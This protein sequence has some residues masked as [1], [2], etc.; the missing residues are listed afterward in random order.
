MAFVLISVSSFIA[1]KNSTNVVLRIFFSVVFWNRRIKM[2]KE[3]RRNNCFCQSLS[4]A[5]SQCLPASSAIRFGINGLANNSL[6]IVAMYRNHLSRL[7]NIRGRSTP[8]V[9]SLMASLY[10]SPLR[11]HERGISPLELKGVE[12]VPLTPEEDFLCCASHPSTCFHRTMACCCCC[13]RSHFFPCSK[14]HWGHLECPTRSL[15][16]PTQTH[17]RLEALI[18]LPRPTWNM[19]L[20]AF[21]WTAFP[22]DLLL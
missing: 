12:V 21:Y 7:K 8:M 20:R 3:K 13:F 16:R 11:N 15:D 18:S 5:V 19:E 14:T 2:E 6:V 10:L 17:E 22:T 4:Y 9:N 1:C